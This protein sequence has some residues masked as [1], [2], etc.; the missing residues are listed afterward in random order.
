LIVHEINNVR[1]A[2]IHTA[3]PLVPEPSSSEVDIAT[4]KVKR[5]KLPGTDQIPA[6]LI[7]AGDNT[8]HSKIHTLINSICYKEKLPEQWKER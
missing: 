5:Y 7:Q 6:D 1:Q 2:E 3:E 4:W 8:L